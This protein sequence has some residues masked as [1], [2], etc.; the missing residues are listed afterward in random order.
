MPLYLLPALHKTCYRERKIKEHALQRVA[1]TESG[2]N[3]KHLHHSSYA[4]GQVPSAP[5]TLALSTRY[6]CHPVLQIKKLED[7]E[8]K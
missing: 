1:T 3:S 4:M 7:K 2:D 8:V 6:S 5:R